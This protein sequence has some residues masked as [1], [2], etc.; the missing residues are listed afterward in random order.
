VPVAALV[1]LAL[2]AVVETVASDTHH[3]FA[4]P[5]FWHWETKRA[6]L[7]SGELDGDVA[8]FG[9]S[10]LVYG[11]DPAVANRASASGRVVNLALPGMSLQHEAQFFRDRMASG[12]PPRVA[13]LEFRQVVIERESWISGPYFRFWASW[14]DFAESR[15]LYW[16]LP[17]ALGF[18]EN[19]LST[20]FRHREAAN[21]WL[22]QS[23]LARGPVRRRRD[24]N[25]EIT[26]EMRAHAGWV[27]P[28]VEDVSL[29]W[30]GKPARPRLW[31]VNPAGELWLRRFLETAAASDVRVVLLLPPSPPPPRLVETLGPQGFRAR[32]N[33][34][35][36]RLREEHPG[37]SIEV[38]EPTGFEL[39]DFGDEIHL[40]PKG[41]AKLSEAFAAWIAA[42]RARHGLQK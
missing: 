36:A 22:E 1:F 19:R 41:R 2:V 40:S 27:R 9:T 7:D 15:F 20:V 30:S 42:Y 26:V 25:E 10:V 13:V 4:D 12:R 24:R 37:L 39:D 21:Y 31:Q 5:S 18:A 32:F 16:N 6:L 28:E 11:L 29:E 35:V 14:R 33:G 3:W 34:H 38:F 17:L 23:A 8:V